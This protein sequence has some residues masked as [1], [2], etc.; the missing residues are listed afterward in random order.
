VIDDAFRR[1]EFEPRVEMEMG[2]PDAMCQ[3]VIVGIGVSVLP[4]PLVEQDIK[5]GRLVEIGLSR[6]R[7]RRTLGFATATSG[8]GSAAADAFM[9]TTDDL[10]SARAKRG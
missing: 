8:G 3:L 6:F 2:S 1:A 7:A 9:A 4:Q 10:F 5:R